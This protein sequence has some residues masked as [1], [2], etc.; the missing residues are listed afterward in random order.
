MQT[1]FTT[2]D[3]AAPMSEAERAAALAFLDRRPVHNVIMSGWM[4]EHG[5]VSPR[6]RGTFYRTLDA[7]G[8]LSGVALIGRTT[9]FEAANGRVI[10]CF[11]EEAR[12]HA[13]VAMVFGEPEEL[14]D[15]CKSFRAKAR[16][17]SER[18]SQL[19]FQRGRPPESRHDD[20]A[21]RPAELDELGQ[22][23]AAHAR[24]VRDETS[25]DPLQADLE[26]FT[27]RC[28]QRIAEGKT[29][30]SSAEN[31]DIVF[32]T[33]IASRTPKVIYIEGV[34]VNPRYRGR[35]IAK[36]CLENLCHSMLDGTN[37]ICGFVDGGNQR[38]VSLYRRAGFS[39]DHE[40]GKVY[41]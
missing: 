21:L 34:W 1:K 9:F 14:A 11:A 3:Q 32:K 36:K 28:R 8:N 35:N 19:L 27:M 4:L 10:R 7:D 31:G 13:E 38:A 33:E 37:Q 39:I 41:V 40:Y 5:V 26:G 2:K 20:F 29:W 22:I 12:R 23:A 17:C 6:H 16:W 15:F 18:R 25:V 30:V 24:M